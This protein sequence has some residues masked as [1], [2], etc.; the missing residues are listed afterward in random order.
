MPMVTIATKIPHITFVVVDNTIPSK[1]DKSER[2]RT[3]VKERR[4]QNVVEALLVA[5]I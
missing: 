2:K 3:K 4:K 5:L 1:R